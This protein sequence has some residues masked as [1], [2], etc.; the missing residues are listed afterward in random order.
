MH[1][2]ERSSGWVYGRVGP[3]PTLL[4]PFLCVIGSD[5]TSLFRPSF[6]GATPP[7]T[8]RDG[9]TASWKPGEALGKCAAI[10]VYHSWTDR[11]GGEEEGGR[12]E[13]PGTT[14]RRR[15]VSPLGLRGPAGRRPSRPG[16]A[17]GVGFAEGSGDERSDR[18]RSGPFRTLSFRWCGVACQ[19][20]PRS[21]SHCCRLSWFRAVC[22][23]LPR[24]RSACPGDA[25]SGFVCSRSLRRG[26]VW[27]TLVRGCVLVS[28][29]MLVRPGRGHRIRVGVPPAPAC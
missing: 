19:D 11:A 28:P 15:F 24:C 9:S 25:G 8:T 13:E 22:W 2:Q 14:A 7:T 21:W 23:H 5:L 17:H 6:S 29:E 20:R 12:P 27:A 16:C 26:P 10:D 18:L 4:G 1:K 3:Y